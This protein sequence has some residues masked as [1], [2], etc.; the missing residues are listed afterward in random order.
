MTQQPMK[1]MQQIPGQPAHNG[2]PDNTPAIDNA[3]FTKNETK[4][5]E[6]KQSCFYQRNSAIVTTIAAALI[7]AWQE[8]KVQKA[9][10]IL[11]LIGV[12]AAV[13]AM[14]VVM[15]YVDMTAQAFKQFNERQNGRSVTLNISVQKQRTD[16]YYDPNPGGE[17]GIPI[18]GTQDATGIRAGKAM[19]DVVER[20]DVTYYSR[21]V[22]GE[23]TFREYSRHDTELSSEEIPEDEEGVVYYD[24]AVDGEP[25]EE[26]PSELTPK[27]KAVDPAYKTIIRLELIRGRWLQ[28][29][30]EDL[31]AIPVVIDENL[32]K[33]IG[34]PAMRTHP[35]LHLGG[36]SEQV[37]QVVGVTKGINTI[38]D[39]PPIYMPYGAWQ[40][41]AGAEQ[42]E[43]SSHVLK[44][45]ISPS[46]LS[47]ARK[48][49]PQALYANLGKEWDVSVDNSDFLTAATQDVDSLVTQLVLVI[50][51]V[52]ILLG[53]LGLLNVAIVTVRQ[54]IH[55]I[56][57]RRALGASSRRIFFAV[58]LES[59][60]A[61]TLAGIVGV[62]L[63][64][65]FVRVMPVGP[66]DLYASSEE[67]AFPLSVA[68]RGVGVATAVGAL[69]GIIPAVK[70][71][72]AKPID[73]I[74]A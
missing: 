1:N 39:N 25:V 24:E 31:R 53:A 50:G 64:V 3:L 63:A 40:Y 52:V 7:E 6:E 35:L 15:A 22:E 33:R 73:A 58:F 34:K 41:V 46:Q 72:V 67:I 32:W 68:L 66:Y 38:F 49:I 29:E 4:N 13:A 9:R 27:V 74:R 47:K 11:S 42:D 18:A 61:T 19:L 5:H 37:F 56:G 55:E 21:Y 57:I 69:C 48:A 17:N 45:W 26:D 28:K 43:A 44:V 36:L 60:V 70:A 23:L 20:Y 16:E 54:R 51:T 8:V 14:S 59:V 12:V 71:V 10:V 2:K 65:F 62:M 30:D